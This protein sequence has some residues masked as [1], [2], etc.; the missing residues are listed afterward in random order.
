MSET[1][2]HENQADDLRRRAEDIFRERVAQ[3]PKS[4]EAQSPADT[5]RTLTELQVHQIELEMQNEELRR[6]QVELD[7]TRARYFD[8]YDLAPVGYC[9]ISEKGL[10]I[11][12]N[13]TAAG[14][15]GAARSTLTKK[16]ISRFIVKEDQDIFYMH[17]KKLLE[18]GK[19]QE[20]ELRIVKNDGTQF[21]AH[22]ASTTVHEVDDAP[23]FRVV[24]SDI[25]ERKLTEIALQKAYDQIK[26]LR[27]IVPIC[28]YC[29]KIRDDQ[30]FWNQVEVYVS[31]HSEAEFSHGLCP[32][33]EEKMYTRVQT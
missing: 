30:G 16:P 19:P 1:N 28:M 21:W 32:D 29:K 4:L 18:S 12:A 23:V 27:G 6:I 31:N 11:E 9:T 24:L 33:C 2:I 25:N 14:L 3:S 10:I 5:K 13:L 26:T 17:L 7:A 8:L 22:L 20:C 15:L